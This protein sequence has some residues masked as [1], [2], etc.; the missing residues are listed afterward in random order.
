ML[1]AEVGFHEGSA[2]LAH[3]GD[4]GVGHLVVAAHG[5]GERIDIASLG[6]QAG[7]VFDDEL[8]DAA[9]VRT[10]DRRA[11][12][13]GLEQYDRGVL[14][15]LRWQYQGSSASNDVK[16]RVASLIT[17][18]LDIGTGR[19]DRLAQLVLLGACPHDRRLR[20]GGG[21]SLDEGEQTLLFGQPS[22]E[23][24]PLAR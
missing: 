6:E 3:L 2:G 9:E 17:S 16:E 22:N 19:L 10:Q 21:D 18:E 13:I 24:E 23:H 14:V 20:S 5:R 15:A 11:D 8:G 4:L 1:S 12:P 7:L